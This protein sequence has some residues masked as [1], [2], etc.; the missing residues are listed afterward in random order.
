MQ[1]LP[2][3]GLAVGRGICGQQ[4]ACAGG[5]QPGL[6]ACPRPP[7]SCP[8]SPPPTLPPDAFGASCPSADCSRPTAAWGAGPPS[9]TL[10]WGQGSFPGQQGR[11]ELVWDLQTPLLAQ[12]RAPLFCKSPHPSREGGRSSPGAPLAPAAPGWGR[13]NGQGGPHPPPVPDAAAPGRGRARWVAPPALHVHAMHRGRRQSV[14][15]CV[16]RGS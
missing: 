7:A 15:I 9:G 3:R 10:G 2:G 16:L 4:P 14:P 11:Q 13:S 12:P 5:L 8:L 6:G 1:P